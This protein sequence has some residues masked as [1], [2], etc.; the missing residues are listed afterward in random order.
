MVGAFVLLGIA[1][2]VAGA[3]WLSEAR[4]G[5][6][7]TRI[8][9]EVRTAGQLKAGNTVTLRGVK[10]GQVEQIDFGPE[11]DVRLTL[12]IDRSAPLPDRPAVLLRPT[13]LFGQW[14]AAI[15][16]ASRFSPGRLDTAARSRGNLPGVTQADFSDLSSYT[17]DI[18]ANLQR[19]TNQ[20]ESVL[21]DSTVRNL[22]SAA[23]NFEAAS[24]ELARMLR[25][26]RETMSTVATDVADASQAARSA[27]LALDSTLTRLEGATGE[28]ELDAIFENT[29]E[30][31]SSLTELVEALRDNSRRM[32]G[33]LARADTTFDDVDRL[34]SRLNRGEG[35]LGRL[36]SDTAL[37]EETVATLAELRALL[38]D[39]KESPG[40]YFN[41]SI[42]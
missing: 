38:D 18:A 39:L 28:G 40:K 12:Q 29:R 22:A 32:N 3:L 41:F 13:S 20:L 23:G 30:A 34:F 37:Y 25:E 17:E 16:P 14:E 5:G 11:G 24:G 15:V 10:V 1:V 27:A 9:A 19:I 31:T 4:M 6:E 33:V 42:F 21:T 7:M 36:V 2:I 26:Q 35:T 8:T